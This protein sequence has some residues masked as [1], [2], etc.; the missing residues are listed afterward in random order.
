MSSAFVD[1]AMAELNARMRRPEG[2]GAAVRLLKA[3]HLIAQHA[4][5]ERLVRRQDLPEEAFY[6]GPIG[7][8][9]RHRGRSVN[10]VAIS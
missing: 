6:D 1:T 8:N 10:F 4:R 9:V 2:P 3:D 5:G 7:A